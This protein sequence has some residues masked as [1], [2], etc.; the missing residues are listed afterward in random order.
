[1]GV[2]E[3][4]L[5]IGAF[6]IFPLWHNLYICGGLRSMGVREYLLLIGAFLIFPLWYDLSKGRAALKEVFKSK[7][8]ARKLLLLSIVSVHVVWLL[9]RIY[10]MIMQLPLSTKY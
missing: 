2:Q 3:C 9:M 4:L 10:L 8:K 7:A 6:L 5:I 1:M